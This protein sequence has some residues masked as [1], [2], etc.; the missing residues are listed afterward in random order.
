MRFG[1]VVR[2]RG[3]AWETTWFHLYLNRIESKIAFLDPNDASKGYRRDRNR[4]PA[5]RGGM[6]DWTCGSYESY[7][8]LKRELHD[9]L[10]V[11]LGPPEGEVWECDR[12]YYPGEELPEI[13]TIGTRAEFKKVF[14]CWPDEYGTMHDYARW[15]MGKYINTYDRES[16]TFVAFRDEAVSREFIQRMAIQR[17]M[18]PSQ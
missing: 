2:D 1:T 5:E 15:T 18:E 13:P 11:K 12:F 6:S 9:W 3:E 7:S 8:Y 4:R 16:R 17:L 10:R 14:K